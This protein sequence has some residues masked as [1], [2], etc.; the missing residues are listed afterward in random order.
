MLPLIYNIR[1]RISY[2][3]WNMNQEIE[4]ASKSSFVTNPRVYPKEH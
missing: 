2:V 1:E 4:L 3:C